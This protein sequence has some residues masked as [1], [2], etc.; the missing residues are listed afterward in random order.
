MSL[1]AICCA[2]GSAIPGGQRASDW[3][4]IGNGKKLEE[5]SATAAKN[6]QTLGSVFRS[7][8]VSWP[9]SERLNGR[10]HERVNETE[11]RAAEPARRGCGRSMNEKCPR[12]CSGP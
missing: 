11:S 9:V 2:Y 4:L 10:T 6:K 1:S 5:E 8:W 3:N 12:L 7:E